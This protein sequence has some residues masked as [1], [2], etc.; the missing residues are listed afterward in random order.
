MEF[1]TWL[2]DEQGK[3]TLTVAGYLRDVALY[4]AWH[5]G[6][7]GEIS[8]VEKLNRYDVNEYKAALAAEHYAPATINR[9]VEAL[10]AWV[11][12]GQES[13][14]LNEEFDPLAKVKREALDEGGP[15]WLE[16]CEQTRVMKELALERNAA[17]SEFARLLAI[18]DQA[19]VVLLRY[20]G[21]RVAELCALELVDV[22]LAESGAAVLVRHGKRDKPRRVPLHEEAREALVEWLAVR[23]QGGCAAVFTGKRGEPLEP[24][25][26]QRRLAE[27]GRRAKVELTPH[28]LRHTCAKELLNSGAALTEVRD[29]LGHADIATTAIY[30]QPGEADL[31]RAVEAMG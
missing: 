1:Q 3:S 13:G 2:A 18:R 26:V 22:A 9:R 4:A 6:R 16:R 17:R 21:L 7:H 14:Q 19:V 27:I 23:P 28:V 10:R 30:V 15:K 29:I 8:T 20:A 12:F 25:A 31:R 11:R 24:R 5:Q